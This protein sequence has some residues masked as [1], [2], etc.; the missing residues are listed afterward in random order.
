M[1]TPLYSGYGTILYRANDTYPNEIVWAGMRNP[2]EVIADTKYS[3]PVALNAGFNA[4]INVVFAAAPAGT[5]FEIYYSVAM[6]LSDEY[7]FDSVAASADTLYTWTTSNLA[8]LSGR[9]RIK[10]TGGQNIEVA[11]LQQKAML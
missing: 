4:E 7:L 9:V 6:D 10:N 11:Y 8:Q 2:T 5:A 3:I 1:A